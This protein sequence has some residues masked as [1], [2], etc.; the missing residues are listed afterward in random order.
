MKRFTINVVLTSYSEQFHKR[1]SSHNIV[2]WKVSLSTLYIVLAIRS[3]S[4]ELIEYKT[5]NNVYPV[6]PLSTLSTLWL[7][8]PKSYWVRWQLGICCL[9]TVYPAA[10]GWL[11]PSSKCYEVMPWACRWDRLLVGVVGSCMIIVNCSVWCN[12]GM[13]VWL[14]SND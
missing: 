1:L 2:L 11:S 5:L 6:S 13:G 14:A 9:A 3:F 7:I 10:Y 12:D 8:Q 4:V